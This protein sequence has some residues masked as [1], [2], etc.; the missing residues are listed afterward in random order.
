MVS[1]SNWFTAH[2]DNLK[3]TSIFRITCPAHKPFDPNNISDKRSLTNWTFRNVHAKLAAID[4][5]FVWRVYPDKFTPGFDPKEW[6]PI[7]MDSLSLPDHP[8][9]LGRF[10]HGGYL[11]FSGQ[12]TEGLIYLSHSHSYNELLQQFNSCGQTRSQLNTE[13]SCPPG[14]FRTHT[15]TNVCGS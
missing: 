8:W 7:T 1:H 11:K 14:T 5:S 2:R 9:S 10:I 15:T 3:Y 6:Q 13:P 12:P 4:P